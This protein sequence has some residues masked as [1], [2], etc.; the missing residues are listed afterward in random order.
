MNLTSIRFPIDLHLNLIHLEET[1]KWS[2]HFSWSQFLSAVWT[3]LYLD[4]LRI[5]QS[6]V[7][8]SEVAHPRDYKSTGSSKSARAS[9]L[10]P[11]SVSR[12]PL[13]KS[14]L[15][16]IISF[17]FPCP[18]AIPRYF[19]R[20]LCKIYMGITYRACRA[21]IKRGK[22]DRT[23]TGRPEARRFSLPKPVED[24]SSI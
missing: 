13:K 12:I 5:L 6:V 7:H 16:N 4:P 10:A 20:E 22:W 24:F 11:M 14:D 9:H 23:I 3:C 1:C 8:S 15:R 21:E 2:A 18:P 19:D 17:K